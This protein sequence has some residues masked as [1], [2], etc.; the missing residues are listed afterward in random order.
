MRVG[1]SR[2]VFALAASGLVA[3][4]QAGGDQPLGFRIVDTCLKVEE[5]TEVVFRSASDLAEFWGR[6]GGAGSAP[7]VDFTR[8]MLA[9]HFDGTGSACVRFTVE[10][11]V[12]EEGTVRI[13]AT[14][15]TSPDPC[16]AVLA[17]PQ[18]V[19]EVE[20]RDLPVSFR[21]RDARDNLG[22]T[23]PCF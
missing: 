16:I 13:E 10:D 11:V 22:R 5:R 2:R 12:A 20:D 4:C 17:Y 8:F 23:I 9:A 7:Q 19:V 21:I 14:R 3:G 6:H 15:H 18:L 1:S